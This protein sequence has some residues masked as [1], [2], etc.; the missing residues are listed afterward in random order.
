MLRHSGAGGEE[1]VQRGEADGGG[2][3]EYLKDGVGN[4]QE[5]ARELSRRGGAPMGGAPM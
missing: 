4:G 5:Q 3:N 2:G 1:E